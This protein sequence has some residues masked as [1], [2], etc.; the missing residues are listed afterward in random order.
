MSKNGKEPCYSLA[1]LD[2]IM[3]YSKDHTVREL[4]SALGLPNHVVWGIGYRNGLEFKPA[5][6]KVKLSPGP[7]E[8]LKHQVPKS[9]RPDAAPE[10]I[11]RVRGEYSNTGYL[12]TLQRYANG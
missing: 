1:Q 3:K 5:N 4:A 7:E 11:K 2:F 6:K 10:P 8:K 12:E 9:L